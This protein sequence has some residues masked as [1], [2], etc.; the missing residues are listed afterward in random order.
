[1]PTMELANN[2]ITLELVHNGI[3]TRQADDGFG[4]MVDVYQAQQVHTVNT[5]GNNYHLV[6]NGPLGPVYE[7]QVPSGRETLVTLLPTERF[8]TIEL[9]YSLSTIR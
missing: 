6:I 2:P 1:M 7:V 4:G 9:G 5:S 8:E 3:P